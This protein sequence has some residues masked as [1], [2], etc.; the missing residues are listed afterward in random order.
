MWEVIDRKNHKG[1][2]MA[3]KKA[4]AKVEKKKTTKTEKP[5]IAEAEIK[6]DL[7]KAEIKAETKKAVKKEEKTKGIAEKKDAA[8]NK[9]KN[10]EKKHSKKYRKAIE[11]IE[12]NKSYTSEEGIKLVKTTSVVKFDAAVEI[13]IRLNVDPANADQQV[14]GSMVLPS[15]TGKSKKVCAIVNP[16]KEK[17]AK[18]AGADFV[19]GPELIAKIEK[20]WLDFAVVV[21]T[22]DMMPQLGKI[23]KI[24]GTKG[25]MPNPKVGTVTNDIGKVVKDLKGGMIEYKVDKSG[26]VHSVIGRVS[27]SEVDLQ[28]NYDE[29]TKTITKVKPSGVK[30][31]YIKSIYL[32]SSMGPSIKI[33]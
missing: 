19:G 27:F 2:Q 10:N 11:S 24:L 5:K 20:G 9:L 15:G 32:T 8:K 13:H 16:E 1:A 28:R 31:T 7:K 26:I 3:E 22:P 4:T 21:A 33:Q 17:E 18:D 30:G 6:E 14:R 12:P 25:L 23:G 29:F